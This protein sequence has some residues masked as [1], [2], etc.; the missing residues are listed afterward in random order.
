MMP[1]TNAR[2]APT[3][4]LKFWQSGD[5]LHRALDKVYAAADQEIDDVL[6]QTLSLVGGDPNS[7]I[8][9][10]SLRISN[11]G[12]EI[13]TAPIEDWIGERERSEPSYAHDFSEGDTLAWLFSIASHHRESLKSV[14]VE[15][16]VR[17][18]GYQSAY[19]SDPFIN[20]LERNEP[21][22]PKGVM[23][24]PSDEIPW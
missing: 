17:G 8:S 9:S 21:T 19:R 20:A 24:S 4:C 22:A 1:Q 23:V 2:K 14:L 3:R 15:Y 6:E 18:V 13:V 16:A 10:W 5:I 12:L 11:W 7:S